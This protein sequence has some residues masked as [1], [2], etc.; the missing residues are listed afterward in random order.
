MYLFQRIELNK[1]IIT[2]PLL[3]LAQNFTKPYNSLSDNIT[4]TKA[5]IPSS[6]NPFLIWSR[7]LATCDANVIMIKGWVC[8]TYNA[9]L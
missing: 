3:W 5:G 4:T 8:E 9:Y 1:N 2:Q 6:V 7:Q